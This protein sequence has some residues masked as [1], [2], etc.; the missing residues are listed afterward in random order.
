[1]KLLYF[2]RAWTGHDARFVAAYVVR[3]AEVGY[4]SLSH[5]NDLVHGYGITDCG[6]LGNGEISHDDIGRCERD[7]ISRLETVIGAFSPDLIV[8]GPLSDC[9]YL[10]AKADHRLPLIVHSW[11]FDVL[12]EPYQNKCVDDRLV[13]ALGRCELLLAD[14]NAVRIN[15]EKRFGGILRTHVMPWGVDQTEAYGADRKQSVRKELNLQPDAPF[16]FAP[17]GFD[18]VY[19]PMDILSAFSDVAENY[20][21]AIMV[22]AG[23]GVLKERF[24]SEVAKRRL[25]NRILI[26]D[27]MAHS[28]VLDYLA[29]ADIFLSCSESDGSSVSLLES[30]LSGAIPVALDVGGIREWIQSERNGFVVCSE[31]KADL[32]RALGK[33]IESRLN[34]NSLKDANRTLVLSKA[35]FRANFDAYFAL[36]RAFCKTRGKIE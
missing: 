36:V 6:A 7:L 3:G 23:G 10:A 20:P 31:N 11:A 8:A 4:L 24:A 12:W 32:G 29:A 34:V 1:M 9:A 5:R 18:P 26:R 16:I 22:A 19:R 28:L 17:R 15:C 21:Q 33:A 25:S 27:R 2:T 30:M 14:C 35:N 13:V